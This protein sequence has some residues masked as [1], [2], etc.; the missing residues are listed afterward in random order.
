MVAG[1]SQ[2]I[3]ITSIKSKIRANALTTKKDKRRS[4]AYVIN[5]AEILKVSTHC[6]NFC[7]RVKSENCEY[8][9]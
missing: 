4:E 5:T 6:T 8:A 2:W 3:E 1:G 9:K 7:Y